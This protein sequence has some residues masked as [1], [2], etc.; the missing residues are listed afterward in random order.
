MITPTAFAEDAGVRSP[1]GSGTPPRGCMFFHM[2]KTG[3]TSFSEWLARLYEG[4]R[5]WRQISPRILLD[6]AESTF[7]SWDLVCSHASPALYG[8]IPADWLK[9]VVLRSPLAYTGSA[10]AYLKAPACRPEDSGRDWQRLAKAAKHLSF[11]DF[12]RDGSGTAF[13]AAFDNPQTRFVLGEYERPITRQH[14]VEAR[15][16]LGENFVVGITEE[17]EG[18]A[19]LVC[20]ALGVPKRHDLE[21]RNT[22]QNNL[23]RGDVAA[24]AD[25][26]A[27]MDRTRADAELYQWARTQLLD[28]LAG[29]ARDAGS[30]GGAARIRSRPLAHVLVSH[31]FSVIN[32]A[33]GVEA[34]CEHEAIA[35][36]PPPPECGWLELHVRDVEL[37]GERELVFEAALPDVH[38]QP[39][40]LAIQLERD[41]CLHGRVEIDLAPG[42]ATSAAACWAPAWGRFRLSLCVRVTGGATTHAYCTVSLQNGELR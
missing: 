7:D 18:T 33:W 28:G 21:W 36:H 20:A 39:C 17:L 25:L 38:A 10:Y 19:E 23:F 3:G 42:Q 34:R 31:P 11:R 15:R 2:P 24:Y 5:V 41:G 29:N 6:D 9:I 35:L 30:A 40:R 12:L 26:Q 14:V 4:R 27:I 22:G 37:R 8:M 13:N 16:V 32:G 1:A